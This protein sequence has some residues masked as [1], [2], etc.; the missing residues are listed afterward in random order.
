MKKNG[1][2]IDPVVDL[3]DNGGRK[4]AHN[5]DGGIGQ[6]A[7][8]IYFCQRSGSYRLVCREYRRRGGSYRLEIRVK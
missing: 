1:N 8:L 2:L 7:K 5:D 4:V 3:Y 6:D